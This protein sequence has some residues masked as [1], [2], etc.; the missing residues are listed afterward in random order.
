LQGEN[1]LEKD[2]VIVL[3]TAANWEEAE[4]SR[5]LYLMKK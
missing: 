1:G 2:Y 3:V 4:K 5:R